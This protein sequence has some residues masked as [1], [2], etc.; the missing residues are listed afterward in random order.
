MAVISEMSDFVMVM[1][2]GRLAEYGT[3][4]QVLDDPLHPYTQGLLKSVPQIGRDEELYS[5]EGSVPNLLHPPA[6]CY[7]ADR[8]PA[9]M[10]HCRTLIPPAFEPRAGHRVRCWLY[11]EPGDDAAPSQSNPIPQQP[12]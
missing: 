3:C 8:C 11:G 6:G 4:A 7:F 1:Y 5:I 9:A 12:S 10:P 2:A